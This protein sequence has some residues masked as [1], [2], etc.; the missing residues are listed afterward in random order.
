[1]R[2]STAAFVACLLAVHPASCHGRPSKRDITTSHALPTVTKQRVQMLVSDNGEPNVLPT[3][4]WLETGIETG[5]G[6]AP[7]P[8]RQTNT[9]MQY[10][11]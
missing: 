9:V 5:H 2:A 4:R 6:I 1:M 7:A 3:F 8:V 11:L 10:G